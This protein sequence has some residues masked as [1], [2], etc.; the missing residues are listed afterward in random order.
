MPGDLPG[1]LR[2]KGSGHA[3]LF[4]WIKE[5][6]CTVEIA[7]VLHPGMAPSFHLV[8]RH[9]KTRNANPSSAQRSRWSLNHSGSGIQSNLL[10]KRRIEL[11]GAA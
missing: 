5:P 11:R 9:L 6:N 3:L 7:R 2:Y 1:V 10:P 4:E 8:T